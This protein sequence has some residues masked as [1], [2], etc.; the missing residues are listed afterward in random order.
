M[1]EPDNGEMIPIEFVMNSTTKEGKPVFPD[2]APFEL[3]HKYLEECKNL[4]IG[5]SGNKIYG[6]P[7]VKKGSI[8]P[9]FSVSAVMLTS[10]FADMNFVEKGD[11]ARVD[12]KRL[13]VM[14][15]WSKKATKDANLSYGVLIG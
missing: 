10:F 13:E 6:Y 12:P 1:S 15:S 3:V 7:V 9:S 11:Y 2:D 5:S 4:I 8:K 14:Q